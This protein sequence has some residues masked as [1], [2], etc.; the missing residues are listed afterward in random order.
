[1]PPNNDYYFNNND[2][3]CKLQK[4]NIPVS[5]IPCLQYRRAL[6][7]ESAGADEPQHSS[8]NEHG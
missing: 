6:E 3:Y 2:F 7:A 1:M 5:A 4:H 8:A